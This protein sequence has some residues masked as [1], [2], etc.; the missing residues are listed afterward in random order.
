MIP[1]ITRYASTRDLL[2]SAQHRALRRPGGGPL[3]SVVGA[4]REIAEL[5]PPGTAE[6]DVL[7]AELN[8]ILREHRPEEGSRPG[9]SRDVWHCTIRDHP[10]APRLTDAQWAAIARRVLAATGIVPPGDP[11]AGCRWI[12]L[13]TDSHEV[14]IIAPLMRVDATAPELHRDHALALAACQLADL[15]HGRRRASAVHAGRRPVA[16]ATSAAATRPWAPEH[17]PVSPSR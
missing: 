7:A 10:D 4:W 16:S 9:R 1:S 17:R 15:D 6:L 12:A 11:S 3:V 5:P 13:R 2:S 8:A 14:R